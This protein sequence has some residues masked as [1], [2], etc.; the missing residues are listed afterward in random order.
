MGD[1]TLAYQFTIKAAARIPH[2]KQ[3]EALVTRLEAVVESSIPLLS[4]T[5]VHCA[6]LPLP[7]AE[8]HPGTKRVWILRHGPVL[9][10]IPS[11]SDNQ[12]FNFSTMVG[13][14]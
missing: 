5:G 7:G 2:L 9:V 14:F 4:P 12:L 11:K 6:E 13:S 8:G 10:A 3:P 1:L